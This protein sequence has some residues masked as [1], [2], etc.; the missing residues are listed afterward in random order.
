MATT[1]Y[2]S[3]GVKDWHVDTLSGADYND[4]QLKA[5]N[6]RVTFPATSSFAYA[7]IDTSGIPDTDV[8]SAATLKLDEYSYTA[9]RGVTKTYYVYILDGT[10]WR[11]I[12]TLT[13]GGS[14]AVRSVT[15]NST[16]LG[17]ISKTGET[18]FRIVVPDPG[19]MK[20]RNF[21][22]KAYETSQANAMR[23]EVTHAAPVTF[24]P[25]VINI[26]ES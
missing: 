1:Y 16:Q 19:N 14:P 20:Y 26:M 2:V 21:L 6:N 17:Y 8:I 10:T 12:T 4:L 22:I 18:R 7:N 9:S 23:L 24:I 11:T 15:L 25:Q 5:F 13:Y 3:T